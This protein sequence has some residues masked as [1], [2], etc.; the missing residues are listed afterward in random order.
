MPEEH[1]DLVA[2]DGQIEVVDG[3]LAV[4]EDF[5][6]VSDFY[7]V[8]VLLFLFQSFLDLFDV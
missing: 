6:E 8:P 7:R 1:E 2:V 3:C 5:D 4:V